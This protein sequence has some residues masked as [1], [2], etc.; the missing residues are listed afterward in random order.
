[1]LDFE[2]DMDELSNIGDNFVLIYEIDEANNKV[3]P[4][5]FEHHDK[6]YR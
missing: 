2:V 6:V 5:E 1:M 4:L 3:T